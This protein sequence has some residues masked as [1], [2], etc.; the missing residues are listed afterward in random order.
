[1]EGR[2]TNH[3]SLF[4]VADGEDRSPVHADIVFESTVLDEQFR[5]IGASTEKQGTTEFG[6]PS[7][8]SEIAKGALV[9]LVWPD[10]EVSA[11]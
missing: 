7:H 2:V 1:M 3:Q 8:E 11:V 6:L 10:A 4:L 9:F 5:T